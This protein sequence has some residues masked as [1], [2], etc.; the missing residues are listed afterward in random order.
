V[1]WVSLLGNGF[2]SF[3][4]VTFVEVYI[5]QLRQPRLSQPWIAERQNLIL[6]IYCGGG[7]CF[8]ICFYPGFVTHCHVSLLASIF[9]GFEI[10]WFPYST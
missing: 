7:G 8:T 9:F 3:A 5:P 4:K 2:L 6:H 10:V 1:I